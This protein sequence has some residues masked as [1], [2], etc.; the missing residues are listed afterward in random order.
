MRGFSRP[1]IRCIGRLIHFGS[2]KN[3]VD[4]LPLRL[5]L[6]CVQRQTQAVLN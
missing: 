1:Q 2:A 4:R 6:G 5:L 3:I